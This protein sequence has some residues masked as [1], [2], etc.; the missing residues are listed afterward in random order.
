MRGRGKGGGEFRY[1]LEGSFG[2]KNLPVLLTTYSVTSLVLVMVG[3]FC[4]IRFVRCSI[5]LYLTE[6][7]P[8]IV[9]KNSLL[10]C[11]NLLFCLIFLGLNL[12]ISCEFMLLLA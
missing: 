10:Q 11:Y 8:V 1:F 7:Q 12:N 9:T 4:V 6:L 2:I 5:I 3:R